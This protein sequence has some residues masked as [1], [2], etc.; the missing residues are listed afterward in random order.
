MCFCDFHFTRSSLCR[1]SGGRP[2]TI[3]PLFAFQLAQPS[4]CEPSTDFLWVNLFH[5]FTSLAKS[6]A[7][8]AGCNL[9]NSKF[10]VFVTFVGCGERKGQRKRKRTRKKDKEKQTEEEEEDEEAE[11]KKERE[12]DRKKRETET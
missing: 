2:Q 12:R 1:L 11:N 3:R 9:K 10:L 8:F 7:D 5:V 6:S 4:N